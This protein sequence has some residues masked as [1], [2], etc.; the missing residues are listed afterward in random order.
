LLQR[1]ELPWCWWFSQA[2][3]VKTSQNGF[4]SGFQG[5]APAGCFV[6]PGQQD[7]GR[8][9]IENLAAVLFG[10]E[11]FSGLLFWVSNYKTN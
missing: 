6:R 11:T 8:V 3:G 2:G 9:L 4:L 1:P 7:V 10:N 5:K